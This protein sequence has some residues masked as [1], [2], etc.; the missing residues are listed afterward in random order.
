MFLNPF[1]NR[2]LI[3]KD[4]FEEFS[5]VRHQKI[6]K[7]VSHEP[8]M[9]NATHIQKQQIPMRMSL[10]DGTSAFGV[11]HVRQAQ[12]ILDMLIDSRIFFPLMSNSG[13]SLINKNNVVKINVL[14]LDEIREK[15][16]LF[17]EL[18]FK[19]LENNNW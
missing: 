4:V 11:V 12:R 18:N 19:Y 17:P 8:I 3:L 2:Q 7:R 6:T 9:Q 13:T 16:E 1:G 14:T 10:V 5:E 15:K